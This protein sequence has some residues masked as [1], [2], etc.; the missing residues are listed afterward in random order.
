MIQYNVPVLRLYS[1]AAIAKE[2]LI[3]VKYKN[4]KRQ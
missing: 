4:L 2:K 3:I 1:N